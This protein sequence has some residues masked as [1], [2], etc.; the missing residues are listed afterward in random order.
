MDEN[1]VKKLALIITANC[2]RDTPVEKTGMSEDDLKA[3]RKSM[4]D[5]MYTF[6]L[7]L[8]NKPAREYSAL[9]EELSKFY[10]ADWPLPE[11]DGDFTKFA[12]D[13]ARDAA[14]GIRL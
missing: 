7:F 5:R 12:G 3:L 4:S 13:S 6:L 10:P 8:L 11:L 14:A 1:T 9:M 2:L